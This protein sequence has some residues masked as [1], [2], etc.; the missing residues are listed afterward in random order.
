LCVLIS[1]DD[2]KRPPMNKPLRIGLI[3]AG[4]VSRRHRDC[5]RLSGWE[6]AR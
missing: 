5:Y 3:G 1:V 2:K 4:I 6:D